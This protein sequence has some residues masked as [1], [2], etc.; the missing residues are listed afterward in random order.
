MQQPAPSSSSG[1]G[2]FRHPT[3]SHCNVA[4]HLAAFKLFKEVLPDK[5]AGAFGALSGCYGAGCTVVLRPQHQVVSRMGH[6]SL[7]SSLGAFLPV[8]TSCALSGGGLT[9]ETQSLCTSYIKPIFAL[10]SP[11]RRR[12]S[13]ALQSQIPNLCTQPGE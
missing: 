12:V 5:L 8:L 10:H 9:T 1:P 2:D 6:N 11:V 13:Q 3:C 4:G 7:H